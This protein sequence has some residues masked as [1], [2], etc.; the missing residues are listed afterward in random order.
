M[1]A[2]D[3]RQLTEDQI[4]DEVANSAAG[5]C[6][7]AQPTLIASYH[8]RACVAIAPTDDLLLLT[9]DSFAFAR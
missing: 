4:S 3:V 9:G 2:Q 7:L 8:P 1:K 5:A 6:G